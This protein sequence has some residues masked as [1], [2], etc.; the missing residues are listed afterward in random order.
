MYLN[1]HNNNEN[2]TIN[3]WRLEIMMFILSFIFFENVVY[4]CECE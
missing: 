2:T 4:I 1:N 3:N